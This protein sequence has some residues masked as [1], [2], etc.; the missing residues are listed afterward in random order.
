MSV[1]FRQ[2]QSMYTHHSAGPLS[3]GK[4]WSEFYKLL[5][6]EASKKADETKTDFDRGMYEMTVVEAT[7]YE[8]GRPY[9]NVWPAILEM[10]DRLKDDTPFLA[11]PP[12]I[13]DGECDTTCLELRMPEGSRFGPL[14]LFQSRKRDTGKIGNRIFCEIPGSKQTRMAG[15]TTDEGI[16]LKDVP[17][18]DEIVR[19]F[20][21]LVACLGLITDPSLNFLERDICSKDRGKPMTDA[22]LRRATAR[23]GIG[24]DLGREL[25]AIPHTRRPHWAHRWMKPRDGEAPIR[26]GLVPRLRPIK[27]AIVKREK[28][29]T[30]PTGYA[31]TEV[32]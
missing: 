14:L 24:W 18:S 19:D 5:I 22:I 30:M 13:E 7:W 17:Y 23:K 29:Q 26:N 8:A 31:D 6:D 1:R 12:I 21:R 10:V 20:E 15:F 2:F 3:M 32:A 4:T 16:A 11:V 9:F 28:L 27:G 25:D